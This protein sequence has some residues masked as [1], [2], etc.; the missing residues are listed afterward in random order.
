MRRLPSRL[1]VPCPRTRN[2]LDTGLVIRDETFD[3]IQRMES[4]VFCAS[5]ASLH[6]WDRSS[7]VL[8]GDLLAEPEGQ[9]AGA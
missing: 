7:A 3:R 6:R 5:C 1:L 8:E 4:W 2:W 9:A